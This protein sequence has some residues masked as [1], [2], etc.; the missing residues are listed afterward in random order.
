MSA[1]GLCD[2][3]QNESI[4]VRSHACSGDCC[5]C[6]KALCLRAEGN[7]QLDD[8]LLFD[9]LAASQCALLAICVAFTELI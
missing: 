7:R 9:F 6:E 5:L 1:W 8:S 2:D 3:D 4:V